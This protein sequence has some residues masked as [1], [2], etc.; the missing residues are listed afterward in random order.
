MTQNTGGLSWAVLRMRHAPLVRVVAIAGALAVGGGLA[1]AATLWR[2]K[3]PE[4]G[5]KTFGGELLA[6]PRYGDRVD[7]G[8]LPHGRA[9]VNDDPAGRYGYMGSG[10]VPAE[11]GY[12][13][14]PYVYA[15]GLP[16][17]AGA[18]GQDHE[19]APFIPQP[20]TVAPLS[21]V[22][23]TGSGSGQTLVL[24]P[25]GVGN[26]SS[27]EPAAE[28]PAEPSTEPSTQPSTSTP[29]VPTEVVTNPVPTS[30]VPEPATGALAALGLAMVY[31]ARRSRAA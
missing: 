20:G 16:P 29:S 22:N 10:A 30:P 13:Y 12:R 21:F 11:A 15:Q 5:G 18:R 2:G 8:G 27:E 24:S 14:A 31:L 7:G 28:S 1:A 19:P 4:A 25:L 3:A 6:K 23:P 17:V 9:G 26:G